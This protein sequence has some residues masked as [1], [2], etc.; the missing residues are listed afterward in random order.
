MPAKSRAFSIFPK[1]L[2]LGAATR[3]PI[4]KFG[5]ALRYLKA[6]PL[7]ALVLREARRRTNDSRSDFVMMGHARQAGAGPNPARQAAIFSGLPETVPAITVN[8]AC[9]SGLVAVIQGAEK[10]ALGKASSVWVG[11]AE[12][13]S[14]TPYLIPSARWGQKMGNLELSDGMYQDGFH[15]PLASMVMGQTVETFLAKELKISREEQDEYALRSQQRAARSWN[16]RLFDAETFQVPPNEKDPKKF[17][18]LRSDEHVR[19]DTTLE[20]LRKLA[21]VFDPKSGTLTAGNS[22]G[23]TD[24]AAFLHLSNRSASHAEAE[25]LDYEIVALDPKRMGLGPV[26]STKALLARQGLTVNDLEAVELNEAFAAQVL[27]CNRE[28]EIPIDRLNPRGGAIALGHPI[29]ATGAR[30]LVTLIHSIKG[31]RGALGLAT[32]CVSGGHGVAVLVKAL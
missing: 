16:E 29:G 27:A 2:F 10:M 8:Q 28:L 17:P 22:S 5:G 24:G 25:L 13:M 11:G 32:L 26:P 19:G 12:S 15:C 9:S 1:P 18:G 6:G 30:I 4:G 3:S 7:A 23:I 20:S 21:P 31:K 14:N